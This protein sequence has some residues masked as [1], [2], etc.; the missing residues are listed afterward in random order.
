MHQVASQFHVSVSAVARWVERAAG[1]RL[2]RA[3][4]SNRMPGCVQG[5]NRVATSVEQRIAELRKTLREESILG[6]YGARAIQIALEAELS[7]PVPSIA[8]INR[9]LSRQGLQDTAR[10]VR[11]AAP[12]KGWYLPQVA[13]REAELDCVFQCKTSKDSTGNRA[14]IPV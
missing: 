6:E 8:T 3:K 2:D 1:G 7:S 5:W 12:P 13:A 4:F 11:R 9:S 10:R 14:V